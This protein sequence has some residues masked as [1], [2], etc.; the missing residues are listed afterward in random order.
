MPDGFSTR[1]AADRLELSEVTVRTMLARGELTGERIPWGGRFRW[2]IDRAAVETAHRLRQG[3]PKPRTSPVARL[4][5]NLRSL[6]DEVAAIRSLVEGD[7]DAVEHGIHKL[8]RER[9]DLRAK[10]TTL[11]EGLVRAR[12]AAD[13]QSEADDERATVVRHLLE[14]LSAGERAD[15]LRRDALREH[16]EAAAA[17]TRAGHLGELET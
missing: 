10:A 3:K 6:Q 13:L 15:R 16:E 7:V 8:R 11:T 17:T 1:Q 12:A 9:D 2:L 4:E 14:A 5:Q